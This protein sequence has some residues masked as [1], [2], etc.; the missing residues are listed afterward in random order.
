MRVAITSER[1]FP[2]PRVCVRTASGSHMVV[3]PKP[4]PRITDATGLKLYRSACELV[5]PHSRAIFYFRGL[6][7]IR[8]KPTMPIFLNGHLCHEWLTTPSNV[9]RVMV[10]STLTKPSS[11][12]LLFIKY[13]ASDRK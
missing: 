11:S 3:Q 8:T 12:T 2:F 9:K 13:F 7:P 10:M 6:F 5:K 1:Q 4:H